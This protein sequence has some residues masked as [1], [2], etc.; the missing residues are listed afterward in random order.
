LSVAEVARRFDVSVDVVKRNI[1]HSGI[2]RRQRRAPLDEA[3]LRRLYVEERLGVRVV[4]ARLGVSPDKVRADLARYRIP[5]RSPGRPP[6][7]GR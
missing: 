1:A 2:P 4:A 3:A 6:G 5:I 7:R